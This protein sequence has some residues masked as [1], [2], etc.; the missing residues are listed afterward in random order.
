M[1]LRLLV[2]KDKYIARFQPDAKGEFKTVVSGNLAPGAEE[3]VSVQCYN[4]SADTE[5]WVRFADFRIE[6]V[7]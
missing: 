3:Q 6:E 5:H 1:R 7:K 2:T 4:G